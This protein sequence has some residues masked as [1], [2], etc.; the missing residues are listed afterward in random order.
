MGLGCDK[1]ARV[2]APPGH[3]P[4]PVG[5]G[6]WRDVH[7]H[8]PRNT[9]ASKRGAWAHAHISGDESRAA[10][11]YRR[12]AQDRKAPRREQ[13]W[14]GLSQC[15]LEGCRREKRGERDN[16]DEPGRKPEKSTRSNHLGVAPEPSCEESSVDL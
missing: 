10:I 4:R 6:P 15:C 12:G 8:V 3:Q 9:K 7:E 11:S 5:H 16:A 14:R 2:Y 13:V 1:A